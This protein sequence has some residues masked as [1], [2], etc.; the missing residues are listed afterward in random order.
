[1]VILWEVQECIPSKDSSTTKGEPFVSEMVLFDRSILSN[2][3]LYCIFDLKLTGFVYPTEPTTVDFVQI[4]WLDLHGKHIHDLVIPG[5]SG[6]PFCSSKT[7]GNIHLKQLIK[8]LLNIAQ[9]CPFQGTPWRAV[10]W[11]PKQQ[12]T[13][14]WPLAKERNC[15]LGCPPSQSPPEFRYIFSKGYI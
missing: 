15:P 3:H 12:W 7:Q 9:L 11:I 8:W 5:S 13:N 10:S 2:Y 6:V 14:Q 4:L 1:M